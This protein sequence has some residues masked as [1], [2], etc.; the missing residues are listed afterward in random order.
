MQNQRVQ[1]SNNF[2][3]HEFA[4]KCGEKGLYNK[5]PL[6]YCGGIAIVHPELVEKLQ[7]LRDRFNSKVIVTSGYRC[8]AY[9]RRSNGLGVSGSTWSWHMRGYAADI[10]VEGYKPEEVAKVAIELGFNGVKAYPGFTH[11]D[12]RYDGVWRG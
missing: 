2:W 3:L 12:V 6:S 1:L 11:V 4:C 8:P 10:V 9:N 7:Q 5:E